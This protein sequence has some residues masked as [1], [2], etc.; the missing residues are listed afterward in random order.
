M[1]VVIYLHD[2]VDFDS[3]IDQ[4]L[5]MRQFFFRFVVGDNIRS[6]VLPVIAAPRTVVGLQ[7]LLFDFFVIR[8]RG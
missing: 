1:I 3:R 2:P 5:L 7:P 8:F 4:V 6:E